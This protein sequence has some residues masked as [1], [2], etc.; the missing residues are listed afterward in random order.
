MVGCNSVVNKYPGQHFSPPLLIY[1]RQ[2]APLVSK[3]RL[4]SFQQELK[5]LIYD[6]YIIFLDTY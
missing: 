5:L 2:I 4:Q 6:Y 1:L 3:E